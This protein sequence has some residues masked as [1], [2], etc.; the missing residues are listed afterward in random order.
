M[1]MTKTKNLQKLFDIFSRERIIGHRGAKGLYS[2]NTLNSFKKAIELGVGSVELDIIRCKSGEAVVI[3]DEMIDRTTNGKGAVADMTFEQLRKLDAGGGERIPTLE[4]VA[5]IVDKK[6]KI[7]IELKGPKTAELVSNFINS[8]I[9]EKGWICDDFLVSSF[10]HRELEIFR[11]LNPKVS[12]G[13]LIW[14]CPTKNELAICARMNAH[15]IHMAYDSDLINEMVVNDAHELG[16]QVFAYTINSLS[17]ARKLKAMKV[18][19]IF[20]DLK[21]YD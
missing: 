18:D 6:A 19:A 4:E 7:V 3:H 8:Q 14:A 16:M 2:E 13:I 11:A 20:S 15:S 9:V 17:V 10:N 1:Q 5:D 21:I 12:T